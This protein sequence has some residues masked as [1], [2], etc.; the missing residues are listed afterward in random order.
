M[1]NTKEYFNQLDAILAV[2]ELDDE[3]AATCSGGKIYFDGPNPD[4]L[5]FEDNNY[6]GGVLRINATNG[7]G[8]ENLDNSLVGSGWNNK[9]SS[10]KI[11]RGEWQIFQDDG[12]KGKSKT[13]KPGSYSKAS[14]FGLA[15]DSLTGIRRIG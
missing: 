3:V 5:L 15:N 9:T 1:L 12:Y 7:A 6:G 14:A 13:L 4:V 8:D 2:K 10:I 11:V